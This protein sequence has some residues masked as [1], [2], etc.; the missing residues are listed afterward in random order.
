MTDTLD[1]VEFR[2]TLE[3]MVRAG[4]IE[5]TNAPQADKHNLKYRNTD[6]GRRLSDDA[7]GLW[8]QLMAAA[9]DRDPDVLQKFFVTHKAQFNRFRD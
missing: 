2:A 4:I 8:D 9:W 3:A 1:M 5:E 7:S 6:F